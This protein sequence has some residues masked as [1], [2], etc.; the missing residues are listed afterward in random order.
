MKVYV[1]IVTFNGMK[2]IEKCLNSVTSSQ[3]KC[4]IVVVDNGSSDGSKKFIREN[5]REV[6]FIQS[7]KNIGFGAANNIGITKAMQANADYV[8]LLNQDAWIEENTIAELVKTA[9]QH[10]EYGIISPVHLNGSYT[11]LD[12]KF[13]EYIIPQRCPDFV[14]DIY[15]NKLKSVYEIEFVNAAAWLI[16]SLCIKKTGLFEPMFFLYG[17]DD[18]YLQRVEYYN[19]KTGISP[20]CTI[21]HDREIRKEDRNKTGSKLWNRTQSLIMLLDI[22][23]SYSKSILFF[24]RQTLYS[25][26]KSIKDKN[27]GGIMILFSEFFFLIKNFYTLKKRRSS[28]KQ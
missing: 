12:V 24:S 5:F 4:E 22:R 7:E 10:P 23:R 2:W 17:E 27:P 11:A 20:S 28:M 14:S 9:Q 6:Y 18:N 25:F 16:S 26:F 21:C 13:S 8:F 15:L 1:V 3:L 19:F